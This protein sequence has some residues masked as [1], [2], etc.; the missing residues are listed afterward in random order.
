MIAD[1]GGDLIGIRNLQTKYPG[2]VFL[3]WY[4]Q[5]RKS[6]TLIQ[7]GEGTEYGKVIVD[8]NRT[9]QQFIDEMNDKRWKYN[10]TE[11]DWHEYIT[12]WLNIYREWEYDDSGLLDK[13][14]GFKWAR[15]G[16]D[17][18]VHAA[19]YARVGLDKFQEQMAQIVGDDLFEGLPYGRT[20]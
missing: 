11:A 19:T 1:Q 13:E 10:G 5:D 17:H 16:P 8:R 15:S 6:S 20:Y 4:R 14:K 7:W 18:F 12:H 9:I 3:V 2:R